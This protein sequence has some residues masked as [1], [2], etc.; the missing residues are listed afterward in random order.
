MYSA[1]QSFAPIQWYQSVILLM[2]LS[3]PRCPPAGVLCH[4]LSIRHLRVSLG[5]MDSLSFWRSFHHV[6]VDVLVQYTMFHD[7]YCSIIDLY[8]CCILT[9]VF[10][11]EFWGVFI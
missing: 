2:V 3:Q 11:R 6:S 9:M 10:S 7:S 5:G 1:I 8:L 4:V